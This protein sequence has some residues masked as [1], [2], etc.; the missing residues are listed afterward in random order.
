MRESIGIPDEQLQACLDHEYG[1]S[2]VSFD[3]LPLGLDTMAAVFRVDSEQGISHVLKAKSSSLYEP[4]C[5]VPRYLADHGIASAVAPLATKNNTLWTQIGNWTL[6]LYHFLDG[7][8]GWDPSMSS[9]HWRAV[10]TA[11]KQIHQR[12]IPPEGV[13]SIRV[14]TFDPAEYGRQVDSIDAWLDYDRGENT[15]QRIL[16]L[17]WQEHRPTIHHAVA[18]MERLARALQ[19]RS[20]PYVICHADLHPG[21][22][23]RTQNNQVFL[24][25]WD[26][27]MLAPKERDFLFVDEAPLD[28]SAQHEQNPFFQGYGSAEIDWIA[29]TYYR[30]ERVVQDVIAFAQEVFFRDDLSEEAKANAVRLFRAIFSAG[31]TVDAAIAAAGRV[32]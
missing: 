21:N 15:H 20:G 23:I 13:G 18:S 2:A 25:D 31:N 4:S 8:T 28:G 30:W 14:E 9:M 6:T 3:F 29:L 17:Y 1:I 22:I 24:I 11:L 19:K 32:V 10:G 7:D 27:V 16:R 5:L 12:A 26:D